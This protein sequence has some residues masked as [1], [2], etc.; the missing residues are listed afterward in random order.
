[1]FILIVIIL[2]NEKSEHR[3]LS[4]VMWR[5]KIGRSD[6]AKLIREFIFYLNFGR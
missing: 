3:C 5:S 6:W 2:K 1:M 4:T